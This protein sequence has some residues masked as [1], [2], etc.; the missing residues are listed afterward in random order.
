MR[1]NRE[2][3]DWPWGLDGDDRLLPIPDGEMI[4]VF[5]I[6][7]FYEFWRGVHTKDISLGES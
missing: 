3:G 5:Q 2:H 1:L 6:S 7:E 4:E